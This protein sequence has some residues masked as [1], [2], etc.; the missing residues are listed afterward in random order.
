MC[1]GIYIGTASEIVECRFEF[2]Y[3]PILPKT[4]LELTGYRRI[5]RDFAL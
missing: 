5:G 3:R 4:P 2:A 1:F